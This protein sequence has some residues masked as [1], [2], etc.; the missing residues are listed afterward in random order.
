MLYDYGLLLDYYQG[1]IMFVWGIYRGITI[2]IIAI[3]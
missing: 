1:N 2:Y 3:V